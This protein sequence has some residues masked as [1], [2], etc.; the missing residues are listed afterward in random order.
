[1]VHLIRRVNKEWLYGQVCD[2][3]GMFPENFIQIE[4]PLPEETNLVT[5]LY[6]FTPE[7]SG[8]LELKPGQKIKIIREVS[9]DWLY[10]ESEGKYGQFPRNFVS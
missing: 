5:A 2:K 8:D 7:I 10:G 3:E 1:M 6:E 4:V 9:K